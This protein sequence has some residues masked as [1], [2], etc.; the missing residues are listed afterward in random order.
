MASTAWAPS[1]AMVS[2][3]T[4]LTVALVPTAMNAGVWMSPCGVW[5]TP[6][7]P[8]VPGKVASMEKYGS[9]IWELFCLG[10]SGPWVV[11]SGH[12]IDV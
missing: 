7:R 5:M 2:G 4:A 12:D 11:G 1:A 8:A 9:V 10:A 6:A 3:S